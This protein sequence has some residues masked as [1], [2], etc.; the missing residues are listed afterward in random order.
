VDITI[1]GQA[2]RKGPQN[3]AIAKGG[4]GIT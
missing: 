2:L 3:I 4:C 1:Y